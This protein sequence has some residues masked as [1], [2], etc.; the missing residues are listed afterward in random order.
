[1]G[2][3]LRMFVWEGATSSTVLSQ[4]QR[5]ILRSGLFTFEGSFETE[6]KAIDIFRI[7]DCMDNIT[8]IAAI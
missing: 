5:S 4:V 1:M 3:D 6:F 7:F 2:F 8:L